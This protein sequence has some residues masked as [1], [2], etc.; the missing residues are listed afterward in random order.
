[1]QEQTYHAKV[2]CVTDEGSVW[3]QPIPYRKDEYRDTMVLHTSH[4]KMYD[5]FGDPV[6][7]QFFRKNQWVKFV[8]N[9]IMTLSLPPQLN[10]MVL[11]EQMP[12]LEFIA[13]VES[14]DKKVKLK[15][16]DNLGCFLEGTLSLRFFDEPTVIVDQ[17][18]KV[19]V[20]DLKVG[21]RVKV[22]A[23]ASFFSKE[24]LIEMLR[25]ERI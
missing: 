4:T 17:F 24:P 14:I 23:I 18:H 11:L 7:V 8:T 6:N 21:D 19:D 20:H 16:T 12:I 13:T 22:F 2:I 1:M 9:E 15:I 3:V 5:R 25:L 10:P